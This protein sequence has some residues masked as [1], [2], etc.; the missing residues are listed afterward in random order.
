MKPIGDM[1]QAELGAYVQSHLSTQGI[2]EIIAWSDGEGKLEAF[3]EIKAKL[4]I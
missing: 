2:D 3:Y 1:T 4:Q